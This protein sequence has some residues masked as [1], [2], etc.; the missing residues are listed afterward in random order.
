M[1]RWTYRAALVCLLGCGPSEPPCTA[2]DCDGVCA[3]LTVEP[4]PLNRSDPKQLSALEQNLLA[5]RLD[6]VERGPIPHPDGGLTLCPGRT[7]CEGDPVDLSAGP[8]PPGEY[9]ARA[10]FLVPADGTWDLTFRI[11]CHR[12]DATP[13]E[14]AEPFLDRSFDLKIKGS[15]D[16]LIHERE[17]FLRMLSPAH[18]ERAA[19]IL[20]LDAS[21]SGGTTQKVNF[22]VPGRG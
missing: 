10:K 15:A 2:E 13:E 9:V 21:A 14:D 12:P 20:S 7:T 16:Q 19:C 17:G 8:L 3:D 4:Q 18:K 11:A 22:Y 1:V 5:K 6:Q